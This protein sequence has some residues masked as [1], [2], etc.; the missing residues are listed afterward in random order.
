[1]LGLFQRLD[2]HVPSL[3]TSARPS[4]HMIPFAVV[5]SEKNII[6]NGKHVRGRQNRWGVINGIFLH[7]PVFSLNLW[8]P[9]PFSQKKEANCI[10]SVRQN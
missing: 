1:M 5:G 7:C 9:S 3:T 8:N 4:Q 10:P 6:V 2:V